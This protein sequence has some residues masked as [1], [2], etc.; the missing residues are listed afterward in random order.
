M[1]ENPKVFYSFINKQRNR[2]IEIGPF[3]KDKTFIY[4]GKEISNCLKTEYTSQMSERSNREN[5]TLF[6]EI[7]EG[8]LSDIEF[9]RKNVEDA[10]NE[11]D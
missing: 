1:K 9:D 5:P 11:L 3:K 2:R 10:I 7:N 6:N 8:D 4:N